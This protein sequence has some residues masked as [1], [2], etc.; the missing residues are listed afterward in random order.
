MIRQYI[1]LILVA[2]CAGACEAWQPARTCNDVSAHIL[3]NIVQ[4]PGSPVEVR[5][6][7]ADGYGLA[8][9]QVLMTSRANETYY[10]WTKDNVD[11]NIGIGGMRPAEAGLY[12]RS[13]PPSIATVT[14]C[15]GTPDY[16]RAYYQR[17]GP[18]V[19]WNLL[20][21]YLYF[22][23]QGVL[24]VAYMH[25]S[26]KEPPKLNMGLPVQDFKYVPMV[27]LEDT[28]AQLNENYSAEFRQQI[29]PWPGKLEDIVVEVE[30]DL[31]R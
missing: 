12:Y 19:S 8:Q 13:R 26:G 6:Q 3:R 23:H 21:L 31:R 7:I 4:Q 24:S 20:S 1:L 17:G 15:L 2:L 10:Q 28:M 16:Y 5:R 22:A 9:E 14:G 30:P 27:S 18:E 29:K 11:G 25:G